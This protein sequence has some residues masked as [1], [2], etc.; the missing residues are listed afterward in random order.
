MRGSESHRFDRVGWH[1]KRK[2]SA[3]AIE[4]SKHGVHQLARTQPMSPL[5]ELDGL[6]YGGVCR[7]ATHV[8]K[9]CRAETKKI[10]QIGIE[11][12]LTAAYS[13]IE[14]GVDLRATTQ[15][16]VHK[17]ADPPAV[18]RIEPRRAA[19]EGRIEQLATPEIGADLGCGEASIRHSAASV[20]GDAA[21]WGRAILL[22]ACHTA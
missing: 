7:H 8:Q 1:G 6:R 3:L 21:R 20:H 10:D 15:H 14:Q 12:R 18:A 16:A 22:R 9:L 11:A 19:I 13:L 17:L 2:V 5:G 4:A